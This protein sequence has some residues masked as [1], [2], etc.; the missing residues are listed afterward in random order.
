MH[1]FVLLARLLAGIGG[2]ILVYGALFLRESEEH[3]VE[4]LLEVWWIKID[5]LRLA[6]I[7]RHVAVTQAAAR[8]ASGF[9]DRLFGR[10]LF[11]PHAL[12]SSACLSFVSAHF[13]TV[14][15]VDL[16][17]RRAVS[18]MLAQAPLIWPVIILEISASV[19][20]QRLPLYIAGVVSLVAV[21]VGTFSEHLSEAPAVGAVFSWCFLVT[22]WWRPPFQSTATAHAIGILVDAVVIGMAFDMVAIYLTRRLLR[23]QADAHSSLHIA[24]LM[25]GQVGIA[26]FVVGCPLFLGAMLVRFWTSTN[27]LYDYVLGWAYVAYL[28]AFTNLVEV[29]I[30]LILFLSVALLLAHRLA[31][32]LLDRPLYRLA[33]VGVFRNPMARTCLA[34]LGV[35][36]LGL[37]VGRGGAVLPILL[38]LVRSA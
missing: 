2:A 8:L 25:G 10:R 6:A 16:G 28:S 35:E 17:L 7:A 5:D 3:S 38:R 24:A 15:I 19:P 4:N 20:T 18:R 36:M 32:P 23:R 34:G 9:L 30:S 29:V 13:L 11:S 37:S 12:A 1:Q 21:V 27:V 22:L 26:L 33:R 14:A 31:W